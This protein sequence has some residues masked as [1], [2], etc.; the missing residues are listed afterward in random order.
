M[1]TGKAL[2]GALILAGGTIIPRCHAKRVRFH[3]FVFLRM[4]PY[5]CFS[6]NDGGNSELSGLIVSNCRSSVAGSGR[7]F[8]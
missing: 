7:Q 6:G 5:D 8:T 1:E 3:L 4:F 2:N